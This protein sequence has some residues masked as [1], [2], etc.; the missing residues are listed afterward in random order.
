MTLSINASILVLQKYAYYRVKQYFLNFIVKTL[1]FFQKIQ[2][3]K[4]YLIR[5]FFLLSLFS[6]PHVFAQ[7]QIGGWVDHLGFN[8][9]VAITKLGS[10]FYTSN[11]SSL[12]KVDESDFSSERLSKI[13]GLSDVGIN[14]LRAN[15]S[16]NTLIICYENGNIDVLQNDKIRNFSDIKRKPINGKK[17]INDVLFRNGL[18]YLSSGFGIIVF[19]YNKLEVKEVYNIGP[20]GT[21]L[22]VYQICFSDSLL[23]AATPTGLRRCNYKT[24]A[25]NNF[26]NWS[27]ALPLPQ[28]AYSGVVFAN[29]V[30]YAAYSPYK[31]NNAINKNDTLYQLVNNSWSKFPYKPFPY[32]IKRL[33]NFGP[34]FSMLEDFGL[35]SY[36]GNTRLPYI[37][38]YGFSNASIV[39]AYVLDRGNSIIDFW[40]ADNFSGIVQTRGFGTSNGTKIDIN[41]LYQNRISNIHVNKGRVAVSPIKMDE[42]GVSSYQRDGLNLLENGEWHYI[43]QNDSIYD[44]NAVYIDDTD[45][46]RIFASAWSKGL[47]EFYDKQLVRV[48]N[49]YNSTLPNMPLDPA[50]HRASGLDMDKEGNLFV[51]SSDNEKMLSIRRKDG[52][53]V[54][55]SNSNKTVLPGIQIP[56]TFIRDILVDKNGNCWMLHERGEGI[57]VIKPQNLNSANPTFLVTRINNKNGTTQ[58][59]VSNPLSIAED[60][61]GKIW[62]GTYQGVIVFSNPQ[63]VFSSGYSDGN[64]IKIIQDGNVELLLEKE[65]ITAICVDGANNKWIGTLASG[66]YCFSPDGQKQLFHFTRDE[67]PLFSNN[68][69]DVAY[70][71][72]TGDVFIGTDL[73]LQ[74]YRTLIVEGESNYDD[75]HAYPNPVKPG[76]SG[77]IHIRGLVDQSIVKIADESG[78]FV[79]ET[80][81]T[82]GQVEWPVTNFT[83][84]RVSTGVYIVYAAPANGELKAV[85]KVLVV[86]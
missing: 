11:Y 4:R 79:W 54:T 7:V 17:Q 69:I 41:G 34:I 10:T 2:E 29:N 86:N 22:E 42:T 19:D 58:S 21:Q 26:Q 70:D 61:D 25:P 83:G 73:G 35:D 82:G 50:T 24:K 47:L 36:N 48:Y 33:W 68:I 28:G 81:S 59:S 49:R 30:V 56:P 60:K 39:D 9:C 27:L 71:A 18:A 23:F 6:N 43:K 1:V 40:L 15:P 16:D 63:N 3:M 12:L 57:T 75:I 66:V 44:I 84:T 51:A 13:N 67:S 20:S 55:L 45:P 65:I 38:N 53:L 64:P 74:S 14:L 77:P 5:L 85:T 62:V 37:V 31:L 72:K 8:S 52:S 76:F 78:N 32:I 46:K 80:K